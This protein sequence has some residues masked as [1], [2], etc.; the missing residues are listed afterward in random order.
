[1]AG[2]GR[3]LA[4]KS[5]IV[6]FVAAM[7]LSA[8]S[9]G[10]EAASTP[11][12]IAIA[13]GYHGAVKLGQWMPVAVD[14]TNR[15][16][17][18]DGTLE[19]DTA[20]TSM[21]SGGPP[22]GTATYQT[23]ISLASGAT[24]HLRTY[25]SED[26]PG[27]VEV[28]IVQNGRVLQ[29]AQFA[30]ATSVSGLLVGVLSDDPTALDEI[31]TIHPAGVAPSVV[32]LANTDLSDSAIVLRAFDLIALDDFSTD[33]LT[34]AQLNA[35][36]DYVEQGGSLLLSTGGSWHKTLAGLPNAIVPMHVNGSIVVPSSGALGGVGEVEIATGPLSPGAYPWLSEGTRPLLVESAVGAGWVAMSTFDW[37]QGSIVASNDDAALL[38][39]Q[40]VR[41]TY[42]SLNG[43]GAP[44][45]GGKGGQVGNSVAFRGGEVSQALGDVPPLDL[46]AWW[47]IGSLVAIYVLLIGPINYFVLRRVGHRALAWITV[48]TIAIVASGGAY[49]A[50][51]LTKGTSVVVSQAAIVH[52]QPGWGRAY[53][54]QYT[55]IVTPTR[56]D[57]EVRL[58]ARP[59]TIS[60]ID[61]FTSPTAANLAN[62]LVNTASGVITLPS[63]TA[64][65]LRG[66]A[67]EDI[68]TSPNV[69]G[70]AQIV[71]GQVKGTVKNDSSLTFSGGVV[72]SGS[73][74]QKLGS[75]APGGSTTFGFPF[76]SVTSVGPPI[77]ASIYPNAICCSGAPP[78]NSA[79]VERQN[80]MRSTILG[81]LSNSNSGNFGAP[82][83]PIAVLWTEQ[84]IQ[85][86]SV[87]GATPRAYAESAIAVNLP[88]TQLGT[89]TVPAGVVN[90]R[91]I[92]VD[93]NLTPAGPPG[94]VVATSGSVVYSFQPLLAAGTHLTAPS[95]TGVNPFGGK[96][97][98]G[99]SSPGVVKG[100]VWDWQTSTWIDVSYADGGT[101]AIPDIAVNPNT[102]EVRLKLSSDGQFSAGYLSITGTVK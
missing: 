33:T 53:T 69:S 50:G 75:L 85:A 20:G 60:P 7:G 47:L 3:S 91:L 72:M 82:V 46:P 9:A 87:N 4:G 79:D 67:T 21:A 43:A 37:A 14:V 61:Y 92:D 18:F 94:L 45:T 63:M 74:Y 93:A 83:G 35:L 44:V 57:F 8:S 54:E 71:G 10:S 86:I 55:G 16:S 2:Y 51:L 41:V 42:G 64:F 56:G 78:G 89:G 96:F 80:E 25:L 95:V 36:G 68:T 27:N 32:H 81:A 22:A 12:D 40:V 52:V 34:S 88:L 59:S 24:K 31:A 62:M 102:G 39:Q 13:V 19:V 70:T 77:S 23:P 98:V 99:P 65:S 6:A 17:Q 101:T 1:M 73:G 84:P 76:Q 15:G 49:G 11:F 90:G 97:A 28:R 29:S 100:Q 48:P 58:S 5:L 66:F 38:R 26:F 30:V